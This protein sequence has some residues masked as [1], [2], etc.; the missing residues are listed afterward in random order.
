MP[1]WTVVVPAKPWHL[2]KTRLRLRNRADLARAFTLDVLAVVAATPEVDRIVL[3]SAERELIVVAR[4]LGAALVADRPLLLSEGLDAAAD[5]GR[6]WAVRSAP[7]SPVAVVPADLPSLTPAGLGH[8]LQVLSVHERG[9]VP[10]LGDG[11]TT[12]V[13]ASAPRALV[14][15]YGRESAMRHVRAGL[16]RVDAVDPG[17]RRDVDLLEHLGQA[18]SFGLG[19]HTRA[20]TGVAMSAARP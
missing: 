1:G 7:R 6:R 17:V 12:V 20:E 4:R 2:A 11:G 13:T 9:F 18:H 10:D 3:V 8:A 5:L 19:R 14:T 15:R 16:V